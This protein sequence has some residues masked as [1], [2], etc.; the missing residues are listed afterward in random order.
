MIF[1]LFTMIVRRNCQLF[2]RHNLSGREHF[3]CATFAETRWRRRAIAAAAVAVV[4]SL[5]S[6]ET[7]EGIAVCGIRRR[8]TMCIGETSRAQSYF[9]VDKND[10]PRCVCPWSNFRADEAIYWRSQKNVPKGQ[11]YR[12]HG[13]RSVECARGMV[14][15]TAMTYSNWFAYP[16]T[17]LYI[18][19]QNEDQQ[20]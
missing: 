20:L 1:S 2:L 7:R 3:V 10:S 4:V 6:M 9:R 11:I 5:K 19:L 12:V 8:H 17:R 14:W 15:L 18:T 16:Y 13:T